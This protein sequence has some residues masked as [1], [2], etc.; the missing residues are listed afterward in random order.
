MKTFTIRKAQAMLSHLIEIAGAI[1][2][3][4]AKKAR[5]PGLFQGEFVL[6]QSFFEPLP[7][8]ELEAW[9]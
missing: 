1:L 7:A 3:P 8:E 5:K 9:E 4:T 2:R 6:G